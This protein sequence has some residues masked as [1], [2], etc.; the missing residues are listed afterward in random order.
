MVRH[1]KKGNIFKIGYTRRTFQTPYC[2]IGDIVPAKSTREE[3]C[4]TVG[5]VAR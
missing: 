1:A 2:R 3:V 5:V 4:P